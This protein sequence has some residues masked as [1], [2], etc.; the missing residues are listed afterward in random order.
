MPS[1]H[2]ISDP[3]SLILVGAKAHLLNKLTFKN[4]ISAADQRMPSY[5][6]ISDQFYLILMRA[7]AHLLNKLTF[8]N[9]ISATDH[10]IPS[11]HFISELFYLIL[12]QAKAHLLNKLTFENAI[13]LGFSVQSP[14]TPVEDIVRA[15]QASPCDSRFSKLGNNGSVR[16]KF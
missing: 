15:E 14:H 6:S 9:A 7:K 3:F 13:S 2:S 1:Y 12:V 4:A 10:R 8:K 16:A 5:H 11:Y